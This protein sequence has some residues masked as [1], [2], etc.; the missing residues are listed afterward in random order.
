MKRY[1]ACAAAAFALLSAFS[2]CGKSSSSNSESLKGADFQTEVGTLQPDPLASSTT[3]SSAEKVTS[4]TSE[5]ETGEE[6]AEADDSHNAG[7]DAD[8]KAAALNEVDPLGGGAF[9]FDENGAVVFEDYEDAEERTLMAAAEKLFQSA[10]DTEWKFKFSMPFETDNNSYIENE[11]GWRF[12]LVTTPGINSLADVENEYNKVFSSKYPNT[13]SENYVEKDGRVYGFSGGRGADIFY[14][15]SKV[16]AVK[17]ITPD[18]IFFTVTNYYDGSDRDANA[19]Y[20]EEADFSAVIDENG[21]WHA[22]VF[23]LPN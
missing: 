13:L 17:S 11:F 16:T 18:E 15:A 6:T 9:S 2:G 21:V 3:E 5:P 20:Q 22:G 23:K 14:S 10:C 8:E 1:I 12:Y 7:K 19:P 4:A